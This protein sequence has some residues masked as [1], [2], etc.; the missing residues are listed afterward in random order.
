MS[1]VSLN[2]CPICLG[3][4]S[5]WN[6]KSTEFGEFTLSR[7]EACHYVF[8]NPRPSLDFLVDFYTNLTHGEEAGNHEPQTLEGL[9]KAEQDWPNSTLDA[10]RI[11]G[12]A[13]SLTK[14]KQSAET[15]TLFDVAS[16]PGF[17][18]A[19]ALSLGFE[20][21]ALEISDKDRKI[22]KEMNNIEPMNIPFEQFDTA[23]DSFDVV[24]LSQV[25]EHVI[26]INEWISKAQKY[27][28]PKG[29]L[30]VALPNFNSL[31]RYLLGPNDPYITPPEHLNFFN[32]GNLT[33]LLSNHGLSV[34]KTQ[35]TSRV[36][37]VAIDKL[38]LGRLARPIYAPLIG[39]SLSLIDL[40]HLGMFVTVYARKRT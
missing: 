31:F 11:I 23:A 32:P 21:T 35:W 30:A 19:Q 27:L 39:L 25:L 13:H 15:L 8:V 14:P 4:I 38:P 3:A 17:F 6:T 22:A 10:K 28:K 37:P 24:I 9:L 7:C 5:I 29:V 33:T 34:E 20:V 26:D 1:D 40:C 16:G 18:T 36:M 12:T 2:S